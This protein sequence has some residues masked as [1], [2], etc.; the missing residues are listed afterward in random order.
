MTLAHPFKAPT[1]PSFTIYR[2]PW[3]VLLGVIWLSVNSRIAPWSTLDFPLGLFALTTGLL[4]L[5]VP[6]DDVHNERDDF[7]LEDALYSLAIAAVLTM[8]GL[9]MLDF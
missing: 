9:Y 7:D 1:Q 5:F 6:H 3:L 4:S 8:I 2:T